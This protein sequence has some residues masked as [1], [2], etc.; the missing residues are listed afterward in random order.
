MWIAC[1]ENTIIDGHYNIT[2]EETCLIIRIR[3][4][5]KTLNCKFHN[6]ELKFLKYIENTTIRPVTTLKQYLHM[7]SKKPW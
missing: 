3:Y 4:L 6:G 5:L 1:T 7:T 2:V